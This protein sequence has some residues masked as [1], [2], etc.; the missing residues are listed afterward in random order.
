M[1]DSEGDFPKR[2]RS[3]SNSY[4][5]TWFDWFCLWYPPG[6]L[7]LFNRHWQHYHADPDGWNWLEYGLFLIPGGF[8]LALLLRWLRLGCR[9]PRCGDCQ[10]EPNYQS[11]FRDEVLAPILKYYFRASLQQIENLPEKGPLIVAMN[12]AGMSFPWDFLGLACLLSQARSLVVQPLAGVSLFEHPWVK[13]WLPPGWSQVLG[14]VRAQLEDFEGALDCQTIVLYAPE[15][16]RGPRKG[17]KK[18]YQLETF[19]PSFIQLSDRYRIPILP[20]VCLGNES[21]HP[22]AV[23]LKSLARR[24]NLPFLPV[25]FLMLV[26]IVFPS[27]GVWASRSRLHYYVQPLYQPPSEA[28]DQV[29]QQ[30]QANC[31]TRQGRWVAYRQAQLLRS[32]MQSQIND[33]LRKNSAIA[34]K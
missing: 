23:N 24:L 22:W 26:F 32:K 6:W 3:N 9:S 12:H 28:V 16:L 31:S 15:G 2:D 20:V 17:W 14:G 25:S 19:H 27:M 30:P 1:N 5:F 11:A 18:R 10:F 34:G 21:L 29:A 4:R 7:I 8:Y 13:W 33:W